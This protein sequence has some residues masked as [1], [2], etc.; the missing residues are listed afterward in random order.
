MGQKEWDTVEINRVVD[1]VSEANIIKLTHTHTKNKYTFLLFK[2]NSQS[3][4]GILWEFKA[5]CSKEM[6]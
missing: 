3:Y 6:L 2:G 1:R 5:I 4:P